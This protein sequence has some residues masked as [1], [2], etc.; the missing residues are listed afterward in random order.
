MDVETLLMY[1][2]CVVSAVL[3]IAAVECRRLV[4]N[5]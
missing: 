5:E 2:V 1:N 3:K 4:G